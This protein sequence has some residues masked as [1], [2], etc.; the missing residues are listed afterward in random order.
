MYNRVTNNLL[1]ENQQAFNKDLT[2]IEEGKKVRRKESNNNIP[3][4]PDDKSPCAGSFLLNDG[5]SY[6]ITEN[7]VENFQQ[8]YPGINVRQEI[9]NITGWCL[10][11]PKN[12]K[13]RSGAKRFLNGWLSRSQNSARPEKKTGAK[14]TGFSNFQQRDYDFD[15]LERQLLSAQKV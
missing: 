12:R 3:S 1:T 9:R 6:E 7:D 4:A 15:E 2:T 14:P 13:T 5:T 8:L 10:S 11:N